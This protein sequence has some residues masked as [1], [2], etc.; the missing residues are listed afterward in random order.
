MLYR[1]QVLKGQFINFPFK[2][3]SFGGKYAYAPSVLFFNLLRDET[4][5]AFILAFTDHLELIFSSNT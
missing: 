4:V 5:E 1:A 3:Y 2:S